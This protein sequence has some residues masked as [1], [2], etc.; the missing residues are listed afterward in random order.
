MCEKLLYMRNVF[1]DVDIM[2]DLLMES[3]KQHT[4]MAEPP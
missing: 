2:I 3:S 1:G 4:Y